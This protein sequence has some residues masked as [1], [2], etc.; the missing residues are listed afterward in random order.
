MYICVTATAID[1]QQLI[2]PLRNNISPRNSVIASAI[3]WKL[4]VQNFLQIRSDLAFLLND[5][6]GVTF[7]PDTMCVL[8][9]LIFYAVLLLRHTFLSLLSKPS[10]VN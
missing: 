2:T 5:V 10:S 8:L 9:L 7:F 4:N 3:Y 1:I 6:Q